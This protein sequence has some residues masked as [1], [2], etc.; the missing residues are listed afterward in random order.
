MTREHF[1]KGSNIVQL[2]N[3]TVL[4]LYSANTAKVVQNGDQLWSNKSIILISI[5]INL[6]SS[7]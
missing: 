5:D 2:V 6:D 4:K 3:K 1:V 7:Q